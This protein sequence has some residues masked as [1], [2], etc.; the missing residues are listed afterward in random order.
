MEIYILHDGVEAGPYPLAD[1]HEMLLDGDASESDLAWRV[2]LERW[3]PLGDLLKDVAPAWLSSVPETVSSQSPAEPPARYKPTLFRILFLAQD[4]TL[5]SWLYWT[6]GV[7]GFPAVLLAADLKLDGAYQYAILYFLLLSSWA[8][9]VLAVRRVR[10]IRRLFAQGVE[11]SGRVTRSS[12]HKGGVLVILCDYT[13]QE[14]NFAR[15]FVVNGYAKLGSRVTLL[16]DPENPKQSIVLD[17]YI[18]EETMR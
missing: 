11:I 14:Q 9:P 10:Q 16:L 8:G 4:N 6:V 12:R 18:T 7:G 3:V 17:P 15:R 5:I 2:G 13:Y 1:V